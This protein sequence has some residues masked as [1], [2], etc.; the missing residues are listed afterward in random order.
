[1]NIDKALEEILKSLYDTGVNDGKNNLFYYP[2]PEE[3]KL[4]QIKALIKQVVL[5]VIGEDEEVIDAIKHPF[6]LIDPEGMIAALINGAKN[7][8]NLLRTK[9]RQ[10]LEDLTKEP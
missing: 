7:Q 1:M 5:E 10:A 3:F 8:R 2:T 4:K 6:D 9:Q